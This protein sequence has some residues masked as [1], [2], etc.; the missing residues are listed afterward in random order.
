M[1]EV[2]GHFEYKEMKKIADLLLSIFDNP[3]SYEGQRHQVQD[4]LKQ[5]ETARE[6]VLQVNPEYF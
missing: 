1:E 6:K 3:Y 2:K 5:L 4:I